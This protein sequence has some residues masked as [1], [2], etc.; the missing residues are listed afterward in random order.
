[1]MRLSLATGTVLLLAGCASF[2]PDGGFD[3]VG[4]LAQDRAGVTPVWQ[5]TEEQSDDARVRTRE[6]LA[7]PLAPES[8]VELAILNN[9]GLQASFQE[10][11][12][13]ESELVRAG[14]LSNP[15]FSFARLNRPSALR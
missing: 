13:A 14:R 15:S 7:H 9:R 12:I 2:S 3:S 11:G 6:L 10:L 4:R 1:M 5:R 8:A